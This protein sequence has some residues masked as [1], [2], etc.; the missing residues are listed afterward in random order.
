MWRDVKSIAFLP[1]SLPSPSSDLKPPIELPSNVI[2]HAFVLSI[3]PV[4]LSLTTRLTLSPLQSLPLGSN[5][6][7][8]LPPPPP[9]SMRFLSASLPM[10]LA[11][12]V[13]ERTL[14]P[15]ICKSRWGLQICIEVARHHQCVYS[16][17]PHSLFYPCMHKLTPWRNG[18]ASDSRSEGCV[19]ESRRGQFDFCS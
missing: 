14:N 8:P 2:K 5:K 12:A 3:N 10:T 16:W 7:P 17:V 19:F 1:F 18:S 6:H 15:K 13:E 9:M 4:T 11:S